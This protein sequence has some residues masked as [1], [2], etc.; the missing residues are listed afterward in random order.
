[1]LQQYTKPNQVTVILVCPLTD[2]S[3]DITFARKF[4]TCMNIS[5]FYVFL[6]KRISV[7]GLGDDVDSECVSLFYGVDMKCAAHG[8]AR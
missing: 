7:E 4:R 2:S 1:M 3:I 5:F 8:C 6:L